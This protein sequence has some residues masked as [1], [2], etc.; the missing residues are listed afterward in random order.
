MRRAAAGG[1]GRRIGFVAPGRRP[2]VRPSHARPARPRGRRRDRRIAIGGSHPRWGGGGGH[3]GRR[4]GCRCCSAL[5]SRPAR[6]ALRPPLS[7]RR[8]APVPGAYGQG[9]PA[10]SIRHQDSA[11]SARPALQQ[12]PRCARGPA[13]L[14]AAKLTPE[15]FGPRPGRARSD[16]PPAGGH[17]AIGGA[18]QRPPWATQR[19]RRQGGVQLG[20][21]G[22][23]GHSIQSSG[24][25]RGAAYGRGLRPCSRRLGV[26][27]V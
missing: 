7:A 6:A 19:A 23:R 12:A 13:V 20:A 26:Q 17:T 14:A 4:G 8:T 22:A 27:E 1:C 16:Q 11:P 15:A 18:L 2:R 9:A 24:G 21:K 10:A 25:G 3:G 5:H